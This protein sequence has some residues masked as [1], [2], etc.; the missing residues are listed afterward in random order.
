V[1]LPAPLKLDVKEMGYHRIIILVIAGAVK[2][3]LKAVP[4]SEIGNRSLG[5]AG[6]TQGSRDGFPRSG[7]PLAPDVPVIAV[8]VRANT[9]C[10]S[11]PL[12]TEILISPCFC[13]GEFRKPDSRVS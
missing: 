5:Y 2:Q 1:I 10:Q 13:Q 8:Q 4:G 3:S 7:I 12:V 9:W 6:C 11:L